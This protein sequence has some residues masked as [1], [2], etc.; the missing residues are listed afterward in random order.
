MIVNCAMSRP[1][2]RLG[3]PGAQASP[4]HKC[5]GW[6]VGSRSHP[7]LFAS[8]RRWCSSR[9]GPNDPRR[10]LQTT[11]WQFEGNCHRDRLPLLGRRASSRLLAIVQ[12]ACCDELKEWQM[13]EEPNFASCQNNQQSFELFISIS[14]AVCPSTISNW[15]LHEM[16]TTSGLTCM[17]ALPSIFSTPILTYSFSIDFSVI[18]YWWHECKVHIFSILVINWYLLLLLLLRSF[19]ST[20]DQQWG[21]TCI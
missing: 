14:F 12:R 1:F 3:L 21:D 16:L 9:A 18:V 20:N 13:H 15:C 17:F 2:L 6:T 5:R 8:K 19:I 7:R 10:E 4:W 11:V